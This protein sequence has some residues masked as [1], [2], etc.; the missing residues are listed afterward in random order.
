MTVLHPTEQAR[1]LRTV[2]SLNQ[3]FV[4]RKGVAGTRPQLNC[5]KAER[6][7]E[8]TNEGRP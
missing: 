7:A 6:I 8:A 2:N 4:A 3:S 5:L 1:R